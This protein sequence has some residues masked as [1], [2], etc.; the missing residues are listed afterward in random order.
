MKSSAEAPVAEPLG[1]S[2]STNGCFV[3]KLGGGRQERAAREF[4]AK[5]GLIFKPG[6]RPGLHHCRFESVVAERT[7]RMATRLGRLRWLK[8]PSR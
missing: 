7:N 2:R 6:P 3:A 1:K 4:D 8:D 5:R